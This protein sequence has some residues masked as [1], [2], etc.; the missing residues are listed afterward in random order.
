MHVAG[1]AFDRPCTL[2]VCKLC[3]LCE[4]ADSLK[5]R[6]RSISK[7][8]MVSL[9]S[10]LG[11]QNFQN[12]AH[13]EHFI[14]TGCTALHTLL[15]WSSWIFFPKRIRGIP[16]SSWFKGFQ[17]LQIGLTLRGSACEKSLQLDGSFR[18]LSNGND[19]QIREND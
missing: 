6:K 7:E 5:L 19:L 2:R 9:S 17:R 13:I 4:L 18:S 8:R 10:F 12:Q 15:C 3:Q 16:G 14:F 11:S 1:V